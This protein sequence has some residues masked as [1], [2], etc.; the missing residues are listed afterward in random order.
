[1]CPLL[2]GVYIQP[3]KWKDTPLCDVT[4]CGRQPCLQL[5][6]AAQ[7]CFEVNAAISMLIVAGEMFSSLTVNIC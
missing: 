6:E 1:M 2:A 3:R 5:G 7:G 4:V